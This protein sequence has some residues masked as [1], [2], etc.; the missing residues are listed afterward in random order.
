MVTRRIALLLG[1]VV[2]AVLGVV[3]LAA[4]TPASASAAKLRLVEDLP[5]TLKGSAFKSAELVTV[6]V[7]VNDRKLIRTARTSAAGA[8]S[9]AF[10]GV[11]FD[12]C[13]STLS[14]VARGRRT[15]IVRLAMPRRECAAP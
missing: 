15:G 9:V 14:V 7:R 4:A 1:V 10:T 6:T 2:L 11:R 12:P 8:F 5:L 3:A 13:K